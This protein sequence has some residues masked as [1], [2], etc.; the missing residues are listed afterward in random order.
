MLRRAG[1][2]P[3]GCW[4]PFEH[5]PRL[6]A[7]TYPASVAGSGSGGFT[8]PTDAIECEDTV[9]QGELSGA[10]D[11]LEL[12]AEYDGCSAT[13]SGGTLPVSVEMNGCHYTVDVQNSGPPYSGTLAIACAE[14]GEAIEFEAFSGTT[15]ICTVEVGPQQGLQG[16]DLANAGEASERAIALEAEATGVA[17]EQKGI[18]GKKSGTDG[19]LGAE[20]TLEGADEG[21]EQVGVY[22]S[23][24][25][26]HGLYLAGE[27]SE[28]PGEQPRVEADA[29]P[30]QI[31]GSGSGGFSS[32]G[33]A[34]EC[35]DTDL[36][37]ELTG[38]SASLALEA[39][40]GQCT[41]ELPSGG[42]ATAEVE[43]NGCSYSLD[44]QNQGPP[45]GATLDVACTEA[46]EAIEFKAF[47][48]TTLICTVEV[49]PQQGLQGVDLANAGEAGERA[50]VVQGDV[51]G[52]AWEQKGL[53]GKKTGTDGVLG[54]EVAL[55]GAD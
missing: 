31:A 23:G 26:L 50:I 24:A 51:Q 10:A 46:G 20:V 39:G 42:S 33:G 44:L 15:L 14:A 37:G 6:E 40:Y 48:G 1:C 11:V 4:W 13:F 30:K 5:T 53:C 8:T 27:H 22:L 21:N 55:E 43:M 12:E 29:Y 36:A 9:L 3:S 38:A 35:A 34:I 47:S 25:E 7:E 49:G 19:V 32:P 28:V 17:W 18:C 41:V 45:Y 2:S 54:A 16:V 52:V